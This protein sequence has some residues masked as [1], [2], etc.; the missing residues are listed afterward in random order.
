MPVDAVTVNAGVVEKVTAVYAGAGIVGLLDRSG[1]AP[2]VA[3]VAKLGH[4]PGA[5]LI[6]ACFAFHVAADATKESARAVPCQSPVV[7]VP[8]V[9]RLEFPA[10]GDFPVSA[11]LRSDWLESVPVTL[12][13]TAAPL[14]VPPLPP[15]ESC[16]N[17]TE[18]E[19]VI[20]RNSVLM[21]NSF[22]C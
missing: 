17:A 9:T 18:A 20:N 1:Y 3:T 5:P 14:P 6:A 22:S 13:H 16:P 11:L 10:R 2:E 8:T 12:P 4:V 19:S 7:M 21:G 15:P